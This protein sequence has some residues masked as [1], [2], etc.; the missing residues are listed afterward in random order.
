MNQRSP[1]APPPPPLQ[2]AYLAPP[3]PPAPAITKISINKDSQITRYFCSEEDDE[4]YEIIEEVFDG[5]DNVNLLDFIYFGPNQMNMTGSIIIEGDGVL[6]EDDNLWG[7]FSIAAP[8]AFVFY[9]DWVFIP[10]DIS[11]IDAMD[12]GVSEQINQSLVEADFSA[13]FT[14]NSPFGISMSMLVSDSIIF[15]LYID[16]LDNMDVHCSNNE[17]L[18][19]VSCE[20][21]S[22]TWLNYSDSLSALGVSSIS[23]QNIN[24]DDNRAYYVEFLTQDIS[25]EDSLLFWIGRIIDVSFIEPEHLDE[26][27]FV[28]IPSISF[29][30]EV[31]DAT[32]VSWFT[33]NEKRYMVP[34][35]TLASTEGNPSSLQTSNYLG[36]RSFLTLILD[37]E[38]INRKN[39]KIITHQQNT[40]NSN[41]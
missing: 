17:Y 1:P 19:Q 35:I 3:P 28:S 13:E 26:N 7:D 10:Q 22:Y 2:A 37:T 40:P 11:E 23:F 39:K 6:R 30:T 36:V 4:P 21:N 18:D 41:Q 24:N 9:E 8:L 31:L 12:E 34:M 15:P 29:S 20:E 5:E 25:G 32:R 33:A 14:N 27:G 16:D 38:G